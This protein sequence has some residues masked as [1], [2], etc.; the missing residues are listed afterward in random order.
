[1]DHITISRIVPQSYKRH[2]VL[3]S[4]VV[5]EAE[6]KNASKIIQ[7]MLDQKSNDKL[8]L[9]RVRKMCD[10]PKVEVIICE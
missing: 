1:M 3:T 7:A 8:F 5:G 9:K 2:L 4:Y 10:H 6:P